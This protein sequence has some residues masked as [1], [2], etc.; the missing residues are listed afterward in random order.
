MLFLYIIWR[1]WLLKL[2]QKCQSLSVHRLTVLNVNQLQD[3]HVDFTKTKSPRVP[4]FTKSAG[5][6]LK[7][8]PS[9]EVWPS[10]SSQ[11]IIYY[12]NDEIQG[13]PF[14]IWQGVEKTATI[15]SGKMHQLRGKQTGLCRQISTNHNFDKTA[16]WMYQ[17]NSTLK[18]TSKSYPQFKLLNRIYITFANFAICF[19]FWWYFWTSMSSFT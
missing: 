6:Q 17:K 3:T 1:A 8:L 14:V 7:E 16:F 2:L 5:Y 13:M 15:F 12:D 19:I 18:S 10:P 11:K 9:L 4:A